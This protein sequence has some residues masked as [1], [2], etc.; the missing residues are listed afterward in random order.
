MGLIEYFYEIT[1]PVVFENVPLECVTVGA[2]VAI[3]YNV[4]AFDFSLEASVPEVMN[5][6]QLPFRFEATEEYKDRNF[7][8]I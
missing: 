5:K 3:F 7:A 8:I 1:P 6:E 4:N 2:E